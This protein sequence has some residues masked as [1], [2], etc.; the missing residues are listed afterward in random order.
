[1][2]TVALVNLTLGGND[3]NGSGHGPLPLHTQVRH[4][5]PERRRAG[6]PQDIAALVEKIRPD[7]ITLTLVNTNQIQARS[8]TI[9]AGGYGEHHF[10]DATVSGQTF[11]IDAPNFTVRLAPGAGETLVIGMQRYVHQPT[12]SFPWN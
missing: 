8:V 12:L 9:Q 10:V 7:G 3:P 2:A 1:V 6:L 5:D 4:F 11:A